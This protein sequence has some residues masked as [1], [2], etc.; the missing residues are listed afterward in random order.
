M[1]LAGAE[2]QIHPFVIEQLARRDIVCNQG[3]VRNDTV[4]RTHAIADA[5]PTMPLS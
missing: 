2:R 5:A 1:W 4:I 3:V